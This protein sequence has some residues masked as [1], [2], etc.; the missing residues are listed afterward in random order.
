M[1]FRFLEYIKYSG[2][3]IS[4]Y[5]VEECNGS[6]EP[7]F[8]VNIRD[9]HGIIPVS[10]KKNHDMWSIVTPDVPVLVREL[11]QVISALIQVR[12][13]EEVTSAHAE[14]LTS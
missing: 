2:R 9:G 8:K 7:S 4:L 12:I 3:D 5:V 11:E 6:N 1:A 14:E 13:T 10:V